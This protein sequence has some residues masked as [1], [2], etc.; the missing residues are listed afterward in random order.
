[1]DAAGV[2]ATRNGSGPASARLGLVIALIALIGAFATAGEAS[3]GELA[4]KGCIT[5]DS[6]HP[7]GAGACTEIPDAT[8]DGIYSG[9]GPALSILGP[10]T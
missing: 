3:A 7:T 4:Y 1:M 6:K 5:G 8:P 10:T 9:L 2:T